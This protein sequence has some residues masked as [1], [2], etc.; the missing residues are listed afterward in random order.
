MPIKNVKNQRF[1]KLVAL[2]SIKVI[3]KRLH[4]LCQCDCGNKKMI[5][6]NN[7]GRTTFSCGCEKIKR[8]KI[9]NYQQTH[10]MYG[11]REYKSWRAMIDRCTRPNLKDFKNYGGR[12]IKICDRWFKFENFYLDMGKRPIGKTLDRI[13]VN[14][15]YTP[16][17]CKWSTYKEQSNNR[18]ISK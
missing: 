8:F 15:D 17:N 13:D 6:A 14:G 2:E 5:A 10:G 1:G 18:R 3:G 9:G 11:T 12:G 7:L 16:E 4:W